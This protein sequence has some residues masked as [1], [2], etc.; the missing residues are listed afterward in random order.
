MPTVIKE[1][2]IDD[3][4]SGVPTIENTVMIV[5]IHPSNIAFGILP[6]LKS[7]YPI[8]ASVTRFQR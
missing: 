2:A 8:I 7:K 4:L 1:A 6:C 5:A 3:G